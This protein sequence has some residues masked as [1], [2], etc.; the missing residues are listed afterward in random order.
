MMNL[1]M[2]RAEC[3]VALGA[4]PV[5][6]RSTSDQGLKLIRAVKIRISARNDRPP[7]GLRC[8]PTQCLVMNPVRNMGL[9]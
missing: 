8:R 6:H 5:T 3:G 7:G 9:L 4:M 2:K 1:A